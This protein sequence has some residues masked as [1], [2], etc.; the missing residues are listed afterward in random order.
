MHAYFYTVEQKQ[1]S[2]TTVLAMCTATKQLFSFIVR[3]Y[4]YIEKNW[5]E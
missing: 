4:K 1:H 2:N 3:H 5:K